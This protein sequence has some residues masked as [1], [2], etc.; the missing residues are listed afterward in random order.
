[1]EPN[2]D[3]REKETGDS[4]GREEDEYQNESLHDSETEQL[5]IDDHAYQPVSMGNDENR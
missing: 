2:V 3:D 5:D 4:S 1:M